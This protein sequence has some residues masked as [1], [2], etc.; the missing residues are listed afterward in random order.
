MQPIVTVTGATGNVG[1]ELAERLLKNGIQVRAVARSAEHLAPLAA[2]GAEAHAGTLDD[3]AFLAAAF[4]G[5]SAAFVLLP[6]SPPDIPDYLA[7]Q[8]CMTDHLVQ[9]LDKSGVERV[10]ALSGQGAGLRAGSFAVFTGLEDALKC[11]DGLAVV[12]LRSCFQMTNHLG[13]IPLIKQAG[14]NAGALRADLPLPM[15]AARDVA[16]VAAEYLM[17]SNFRGYQVRNLLGPRAYTP[18]EA[19]AILG[20]AIGRPD[21]AYV[22][23]SYDESRANLLRLGWSASRV[24]N[25]LQ[26]QAALNEGPGNIYPPR[27][28]AN[29]TSTTLE[30]FARDTFAPAYQAG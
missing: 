28:A 25:L 2:Q 5:A 12:A 6:G 26:L 21:L 27:D 8:A 15:I 4:R 24:E 13:A 17:T 7:H 20:A 22:Q 11:L 10:V 14:I 9:A 3:T 30:E 18:R 19:T 23:W 1:K 16:A 29:T